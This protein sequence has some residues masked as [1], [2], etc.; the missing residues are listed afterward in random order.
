MRPGQKASIRI[1]FS[2]HQWTINSNVNDFNH[3][4]WCAAFHARCTSKSTIVDI[5]RE[6][7]SREDRRYK[8]CSIYKTENHFSELTEMC[9]CVCVCAPVEKYI[10]TALFNW[11]TS[12]FLFAYFLVQCCIFQPQREKMVLQWGHE[13]ENRYLAFSFCTNKKSYVGA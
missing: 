8:N 12:A 4:P 5:Q 1:A 13:W 3:W 10:S 7:G 9:L 2:P 11:V 6:T